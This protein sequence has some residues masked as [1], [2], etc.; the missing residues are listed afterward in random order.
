[1]RLA[2]GIA[3]LD[4]VATIEPDFADLVERLGRVVRLEVTDLLVGIASFLFGLLPGPSESNHT[5]PVDAA[6][7]GEPGDG[8]AL[9]PAPGRVGPIAGS[10]VVGDLLAGADRVAI[11]GPG[12]ER[13]QL[14][15]QRGH[16]RLVEQSHP[17][18]ELTLGDKGKALVLEAKRHQVL[19]AKPGADLERLQGELEGPPVIARVM[20]LHPLAARQV[21]V[22]DADRFI[23]Q[24]PLRLAEPGGADRRGLPARVILR[25]IQRNESGSTRFT[26]LETERKRP[27]ARADA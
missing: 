22:F 21:S 11:D 20:S 5:G 18:A 26:R 16:G 23:L 13:S 24:Q 15:R 27:L 8:L 17:F 19:V 12:R 14:A 6:H 25:Q 7:P 2:E 10:L 3:G 9:T 1:M 4:E